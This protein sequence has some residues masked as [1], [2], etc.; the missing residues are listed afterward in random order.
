MF[1]CAVVCLQC[2]QLLCCQMTFASASSEA[3][4]DGKSVDRDGSGAHISESQNQ[5]GKLLLRHKSLCSAKISIP[6]GTAPMS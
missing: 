5:S 1:S 3:G 2:Y 4:R 6:P